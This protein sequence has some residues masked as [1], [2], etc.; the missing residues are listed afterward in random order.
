MSLT[1]ASELSVMLSA[2]LVPAH[3]ADQ[4]LTVL[5]LDGVAPVRRLG[6]DGVRRYRGRRGFRGDR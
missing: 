1:F 6:H 5:S 2:R 4:V 3:D